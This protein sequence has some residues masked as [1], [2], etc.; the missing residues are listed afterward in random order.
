MAQAEKLR[1]LL[2]A[3]EAEETEAAR[4]VG[5]INQILERRKELL[6]EVEKKKEALAIRLRDVTDSSRRSALQSGNPAALS[7]GVRYVARIKKEIQTVDREVVQRRAEVAKAEERLRGAEQDLI[8]ARIEKKKVEK[9][10]E[11]REFEKQVSVGA[12]EEAALED[13]QMNRPKR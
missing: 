4:T 2:K 12:R 5:E 13:L 6:A 11:S 10:L 3:R 1:P 7:T 8:E 9:L